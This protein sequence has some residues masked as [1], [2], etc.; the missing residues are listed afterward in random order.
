MAN[1]GPQTIKYPELK[2]I[3]KR[4]VSYFIG[5]WKL[6]AIITIITSSVG[7]IYGKLQ[8]SSYKATATF[9]V[10]DKSG[11]RGGGLSGLASQFGIDVGGLTGGGAGLFDGDNILEIMKSR[12]IIEK[13]LL[14]KIEEDIPQKGQTIADY[15][16]TISG[17][18]KSL[19]SKNITAKTLNFAA[20][21]EDSKHTLIQDSVLYLMYS[22]I[23]KNL[24][25]EKKNKKS[26]IITLE[27]S[28]S[29]Q[30]FSKIFEER[31]MKQTSDLYIDIK[32]GN[33]S[34][35]IE[36]IQRKADSLQYTLNS[37]TDRRNY[38]NLSI[39]NEGITRDKN[40]TSA[41]Y[42][43]VVKNLETMKLTLINQ[44]PVIQ[45]L[46][47]PKFPL[48]NQRTPARY[49]LLIGFAVGFVISLFY[50]LYKYTE[51]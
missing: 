45:I 35:S 34:R 42:G 10:E 50:A 11:S 14:S 36:K 47:A 33:L 16:L 25:V 12:A 24:N 39:P 51:N 20:L 15:Y 38:I 26:S 48:F 32:T 19:A 9:I 43:E 30:V 6:I 31:L 17:M 18:D 7:L 4:F 22:A 1:T 23:N 40:V 13:V 46:D 3:I 8:P 5:Q 27:V 28:S 37:T 44:T 49:F 41:L 2:E 29:D 21:E